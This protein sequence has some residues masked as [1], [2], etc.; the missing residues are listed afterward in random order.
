MSEVKKKNGLTDARQKS[1]KIGTLHNDKTLFFRVAVGEAESHDGELEYEMST[2]AKSGT[3]IIT[4]KQTGNRFVLSWTEIL[5][6]AVGA[7]IDKE[8]DWS[9]EEQQDDLPKPF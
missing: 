8:Q 9:E 3:P 5:Q 4:S 6:M 2:C 7:G 1:C